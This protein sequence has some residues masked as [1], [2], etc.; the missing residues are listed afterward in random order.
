MKTPITATA[1]SPVNLSALAAGI[2]AALPGQWS[3][4]NVQTYPRSDGEFDLTRAD[5]LTLSAVAGGYRNAGRMTI[6]HSRPR[7]AK[8]G[9]VDLWG[10]TSKGEPSGQIATPSITVSLDK[11]AEAIARDI[12]RRLLTDAERVEG[13]ARA[14]VARDNAYH[15][16]K[17]ALLRA[18]SEAAGMADVPRDHYS[19]EPTYHSLPIYLDPQNRPNQSYSSIASVTFPGSD[20]CEFAIRANAAQARALIAFVRS[21]EFRAAK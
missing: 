5:G 2:A 16:G 14:S 1:L 15:D 10:D 21:A 8:G 7:T 9:Y 4:S 13:L 20:E 6:S 3:A 12:A 19:K 18:V 17:L 11:D